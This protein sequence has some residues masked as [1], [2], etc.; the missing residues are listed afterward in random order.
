[1]G[2]KSPFM[3]YYNHY[4]SNRSRATHVPFLLGGLVAYEMLSQ[5]MNDFVHYTVVVLFLLD[6]STLEMMPSQNEDALDEADILDYIIHH[7]SNDSSYKSIANELRK[8]F[9]AIE[10]IALAKTYLLSKIQLRLTT[11]LLST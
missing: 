11:S 4:R 2:A 3:I 9:N 5:L 8:A 7:T 10:M 6:S 1:M